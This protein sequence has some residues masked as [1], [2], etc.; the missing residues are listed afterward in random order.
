MS[1][2][3]IALPA[4]PLKAVR[5]MKSVLAR[6]GTI[7][8]SYRTYRGQKLGPYY[9]LAFRDEG[10]QRS[11]YLGKSEIILRQVRNLLEKLQKP[12]KTRH[13]LR[14]AQKVMQ[15]A[16]KKHM[17]RFRVDLLR[18][19]LQLRGYAVRGWRRYRRLRSQRTPQAPRDGLRNRLLRLL[20]AFQPPMRG[21]TL[22][23]CPF[24]APVDQKTSTTACGLYSST[25]NH[26]L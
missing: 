15:A 18:V 24:A 19:G 1:S 14:H 9:R 25:T 5:A 7:I 20:S 10:R 12:L 22:P 17:A 3:P 21:P 6:Q 16:M 2:T 23:N 26:F 8:A 11:I 4:D 13:N